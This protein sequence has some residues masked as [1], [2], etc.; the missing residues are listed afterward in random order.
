MVLIF[1]I[2]WLSI[3]VMVLSFAFGGY[4]LR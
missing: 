4:Q 1:A 3:A 2:G